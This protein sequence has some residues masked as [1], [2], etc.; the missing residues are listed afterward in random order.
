[1]TWSTIVMFVVPA[2]FLRSKFR[3]RNQ[4]KHDNDINDKCR[5]KNRESPHPLS[6]I[7]RCDILWVI[8]RIVNSEHGMNS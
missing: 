2:S 8:R 1:M 7:S 5:C 6:H 4:G 3:N